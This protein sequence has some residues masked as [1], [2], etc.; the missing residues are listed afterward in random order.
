MGGVGSKKF[1]MDTPTSWSYL[2]AANGLIDCG[3]RIR[4][5]LN[6]TGT[7]YDKSACSNEQVVD[8]YQGLITDQYQ[9]ITIPFTS[10]EFHAFVI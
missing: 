10:H 7:F 8:Q 5:S 4:K 2:S 9:G 1:P 6:L 3:I